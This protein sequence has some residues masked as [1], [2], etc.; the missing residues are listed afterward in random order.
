MTSVLYDAQGP[1]ARRL[2]LIGTELVGK[3]VDMVRQLVPKLIGLIALGQGPGSETVPF[4]ANWLQLSRAA[5]VSP[6][7]VWISE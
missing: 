6:S 4:V 1:R 3:R 7:G 2:T 5:A